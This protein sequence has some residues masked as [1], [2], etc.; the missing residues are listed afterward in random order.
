MAGN[1]GSVCSIQRDGTADNGGSP[2]RTSAVPGRVVIA[3]E[4]ARTGHRPGRATLSAVCLRRQARRSAQR[5]G[6]SAPSALAA[7]G[8]RGPCGLAVEASP[9]S[10]RRGGGG[11]RRLGLVPPVASLGWHS[12]RLASRR[13]WRQARR[14]AQRPGRSAPSALAALGRRGPCGL[15]DEAAP[16]ELARDEL[17]MLP[18]WRAGGIRSRCSVVG[19]ESRY[20]SLLSHQSIGSHL[21]SRSS[22][23]P[24]AQ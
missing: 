21:Q 2:R 4:L 24:A 10:C 20:S 17:K 11:A 3:V 13:R 7:L 1:K 22:F 14:S 18:P 19:A 15:A 23:S 6:R 9:A 8:R 12:P 16:P 5:P